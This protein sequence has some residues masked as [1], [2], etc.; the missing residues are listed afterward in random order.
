ML[1][2]VRRKELL[3]VVFFALFVTFLSTSSYF[4]QRIRRPANHVFIGLPH[5]FEDYYYY[6][7]Q[8]YQGAHGGWLTLNNFTHEALPPTIV[9]LNNIILGKIG[10]LLGLA[11]YTSYNLSLLLLKFVF[12]IL[13]YRV[14]MIIFPDKVS[15]RLFAFLIFLFSTSFPVVVWSPFGIESINPLLIFR[16]KNTFFS[17]F[18]NVPGPYI[19]NILFLLLVIISFR[20]P[21]RSWFYLLS[22]SI[23]VLWLTVSDS[24]KSF[25]FLAFFI[26]M[27]L[28][29][30]PNRFSFI[31]VAVAAFSFLLPVIF[32]YRFLS[33]DP[34]YM[35]ALRWDYQEYFNQF[36]YM[37]FVSYIHSFGMLGIL[38]CLGFVSAF[39]KKNTFF[40]KL[41][42]AISLI[43][44]IGFFIP[45]IIHLPIAGFRF[46]LT[47][48]YLFLAIV[49][50]WGILFL[51]KIFK[52]KLAL[53]IIVLYLAVSLVTIYSSFIKEITPLAEPEF[54]F[55]YLPGQ[56]YQ[57]FMAL[58][59]M[60]PK[61]AIVL[62]SPRTSTDLFIPGLT[63]K[64]TFTG[65]SL[66]TLNS[67]QKDK[68]ADDFFY[69]YLGQDKALDFLRKNNIKYVVFTFYSHNFANDELYKHYP[70]LRQ[71]YRNNLM[72]VYSY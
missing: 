30:R 32:L 47:S 50:L 31:P 29:K 67:P 52:R 46:I 63:G 9:Y 55:A 59:K 13:C 39:L 28:L 64:K 56:V 8:F 34:V 6:L 36:N 17:R 53:P 12:I 14:L 42:I 35:Q 48:T 38:V 69:Q 4:A 3:L 15:L 41:I 60:E 72:I 58:E 65:H 11:P 49:A 18:G 10:G 21:K 20:P 40:E 44:L 51:E 43:S 5:Y 27:F 22:L 19:D 62:A 23:L 37:N 24:A 57:G 68:E 45:K 16:A 26:L 66:T 71:V 25:V 1:K 33:N 7:D 70:F 54:H 61:E 2:I